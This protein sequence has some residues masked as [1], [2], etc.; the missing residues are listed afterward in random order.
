MSIWRAGIQIVGRNVCCC[1]AALLAQQ[2][3][4]MMWALV[5]GSEHFNLHLSSISSIAQIPVSKS[6]SSPFFDFLF[7][8][9]GKLQLKAHRILHCC[10]QHPAPPCMPMMSSL[11]RDAHVVRLNFVGCRSTPAELAWPLDP[12]VGNAW[13]LSRAWCH[14]V[15]ACTWTQ[16]LLVRAPPHRVKKALPGRGNIVLGSI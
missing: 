7:E 15:A 1:P 13:P 3:S 8:H 5:R 9:G 12:Y 16:T 14:V 2:G 6:P 4:T 11:S 10:S